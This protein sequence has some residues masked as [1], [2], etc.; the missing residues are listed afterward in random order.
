MS[1]GDS[2]RSAPISTSDLVESVEV[3]KNGKVVQQDNVFH[4]L[5]NWNGS[6]W[7]IVGNDSD[8]EQAVRVTLLKPIDMLTHWRFEAASAFA[9]YEICPS[10][11][12]TGYE[13]DEGA[14]RIQVDGAI[15][16]EEPKKVHEGMWCFEDSDEML[17]YRDVIKSGR[18]M[19]FKLPKEAN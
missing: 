1:F 7:L 8:E 14:L 19:L 12:S 18:A 16:G 11:I 15:A 3:F 9:I 13:E 6:L 10:R 17:K 5:K 4:L 2:L